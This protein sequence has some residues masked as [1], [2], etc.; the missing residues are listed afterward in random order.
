MVEAHGGLGELLVAVYL[1]IA[2][3]SFV[4]AKRKGLPAWV[5]GSAHALLG[6]QIIMG[7]I[8]YAEHPHVMP[9]SHVIAALLTLPALG[10]VAPLRRR[11]GRAQAV[12]TSAFIVAVLAAIA[13]MIAKTR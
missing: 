12:G 7:I 11:M 13:V 8:L 6:V 5:T 4:L 10:L 1:A 9:I 2:I 3:L